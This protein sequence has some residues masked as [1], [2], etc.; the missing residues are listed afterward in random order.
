[1]QS[2]ASCSLNYDTAMSFELAHTPFNYL[3]FG[4]TLSDFILHF[5]VG[6]AHHGRT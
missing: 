5:G 4:F 1:M 2:V 3:K 6:R